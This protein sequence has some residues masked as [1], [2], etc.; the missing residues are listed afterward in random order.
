MI[1]LHTTAR[2]PTTANA[3]AHYVA[4]MYRRN[5]VD[6]SSDSEDSEDE[7]EDEEEE[8]VPDL[9]DDDDDA[10]SECLRFSIVSL[11]SRNPISFFPSYM[12][13]HNNYN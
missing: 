12:Y 5:D 10:T 2:L 6:S 9:I 4:D 13:N 3:L 8:D 11:F 7:D 1:F